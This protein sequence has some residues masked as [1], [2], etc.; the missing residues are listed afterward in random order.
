MDYGQSEFDPFSTVSIVCTCRAET[1]VLSEPYRR[2]QVLKSTTYGLGA[3]QDEHLVIKPIRG[4]GDDTQV[5][6]H[7]NSLAWQ[8]APPSKLFYGLK[9]DRS[10]NPEQAEIMVGS[11]K[12]RGWEG[13]IGIA[14]VEVIHH[15][16]HLDF[17]QELPTPEQQR[18]SIVFH[19]KGVG[20][21]YQM[22]LSSSGLQLKEG[23]EACAGDT[24]R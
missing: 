7:T 6:Y 15:D 12:Y 17:V 20:R 1:L 10:R 18:R 9:R 22:E 11:I 21:D 8:G 3:P 16:D 5:L 14:K 19:H 24:R 23:N 4:Y 2:F 13:L